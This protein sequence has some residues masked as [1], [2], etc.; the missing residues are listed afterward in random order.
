MEFCFRLIFAILNA[1]FENSSCGLGFIDLAVRG[2]LWLTNSSQCCSNTHTSNRT[3]WSEQLLIRSSRS[4]LPSTPMGLWIWIAD[5]VSRQS[6]PNW[7]NDL[8]H[9]HTHTLTHNTLKQNRS[10]EK[11]ASGSPERDLSL[12]WNHFVIAHYFTASFSTLSL[13]IY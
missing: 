2:H 10:L 12:N 6:A 5:S 3:G 8:S 7:D 1:R 13:G 11:S 4:A 9:T